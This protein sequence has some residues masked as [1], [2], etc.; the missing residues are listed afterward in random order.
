MTFRSSKIAVSIKELEKEL[1]KLGVHKSGVFIM[2]KKVPSVLIKFKKVPFA[3]A[4]ILKQEMLSLGGDAALP[5]EVF[6]K[7]REEFDLILIGNFLHFE[8]LCKKLK[9]QSFSLPRKAQEIERELF[10]LR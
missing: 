8:K 4:L 1:R 9:T 5:K 2:K 10:S 3:E 7:E 6:D